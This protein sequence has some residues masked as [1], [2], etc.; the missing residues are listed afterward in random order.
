MS[1]S[2]FKGNFNKKKKNFH[3]REQKDPVLTLFEDQNMLSTEK[4]SG[5]H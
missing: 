2:M 3:S 5:E 4:D 1:I